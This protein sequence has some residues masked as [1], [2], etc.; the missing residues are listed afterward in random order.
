MS[1]PPQLGNLWTRAP[2]GY[3]SFGALGGQNPNKPAVDLML[4]PLQN[5][6]ELGEYVGIDW[7]LTGGGDTEV[8]TSFTGTLSADTGTGDKSVIYSSHVVY[9]D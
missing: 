2:V 7:Y 1:T 9:Q 8:W 6:F 5:N 3:G 4:H